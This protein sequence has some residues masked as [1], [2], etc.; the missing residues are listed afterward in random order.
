MPMSHQ[1]LRPLA[2]VV[3]AL[4]FLLLT[5][6]GDQLVTQSGDFLRTIQDA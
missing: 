5:L 6:A 4:Q 1:L 3:A 2:T